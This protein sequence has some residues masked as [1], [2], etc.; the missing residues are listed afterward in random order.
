[1][2]TV[3]PR[4]SGLR[5]L[6]AAAAGHALAWYSL[7]N[8]FVFWLV[9]RGASDATANTAYGN[10]VVAAYL[11]PL[12]GGIVASGMLTRS[13]LGPR[14]TAIAGGVIATLGY[15]ATTYTAIHPHVPPLFPVALVS[16]GV[17]LSKPNL[18]A[19]VG[20][21]F[22]TGSHFADAAYA[23]Y[24]SYLNVGSLGA[25]LLGGWLST[26][27]GYHAAFAVAVVGELVVVA[28]LLT[29][30]R[31][32]AVADQPSSLQALVGDG[33]ELPGKL[34]PDHVGVDVDPVVARNMAAARRRRLVALWVFFALA[35]LSFWPAYSQNGSGLNLWALRHT[36][37]VV[38]VILLK[39]RVH[40]DV[41]AA[42]FAAV[43][44][45]ICI[46]AS[47]PLVGLFTRLRVALSTS[48]FV[49]YV[50]MAA[51]F[52]TLLLAPA[53][54]APPSYLVAAIVLS[55]LSEV[56]I[57][58]IGLAQVAKLAPRHQ[59]ST[60]MA[61]WFLTVAC[62]G[63][64]AGLLGSRLELRVGFGVLTIAA[65]LAGAITLLLRRHLDVAVEAPGAAETARQTALPMSGMAAAPNGL[66]A[67]PT[68]S[69]EVLP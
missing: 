28:A 40:Y 1:M 45:V 24:Y 47:V 68:H 10:L 3:D 56:L 55:S 38:D 37:R 33:V 22:P 23:R 62:G 50:L 53:Q 32:L 25:P 59:T 41:P 65:L 49:G 9:S 43:N 15:A 31:S 29:G 20:R 61:V 34:L 13:G 42:W 18:S 60:Y 12:L 69:G 4:P 54:A 64:L 44:N 46:V 21:M 57:S 27:Y 63:K 58:T 30:R 2:L 11:L 17:G 39:H 6:Y 14:R 51:S 7:Y 35:A 16:L 67:L 8:L 48:T 26:A 66:L 19:L 5:Y 36:V 52:G